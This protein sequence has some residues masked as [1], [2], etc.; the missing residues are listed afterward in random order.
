MRD[1]ESPCP[2]RLQGAEQEPPDSLNSQGTKGVPSTTGALQGASG[3]FLVNSCLVPGTEREGLCGAGGG[4]REPVT[5]KALHTGNRSWCCEDT[6][7]QFGDQKAQ[8]PPAF[9]HRG[10]Y[11]A[12]GEHQVLWS[13]C[14]QQ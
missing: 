13:Q 1:P 9:P 7:P 3:P 14:S 6:T 5:R 12:L 2:P 4:I 8:I 11:V 10:S